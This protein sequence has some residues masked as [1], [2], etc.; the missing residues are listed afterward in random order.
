VNA[1][2]A[3][4]DNQ[5]HIDRQPLATTGAAILISADAMATMPFAYQIA[6]RQ[7][8]RLSVPAVA[9]KRPCDGAYRELASPPGRIIITKTGI[10]RTVVHQTE[11]HQDLDLRLSQSPHQLGR[12]RICAGAHNQ[13]IAGRSDLGAEIREAFQKVCDT[14]RHSI[15]ASSK[16]GTT[17][18]SSSLSIGWDAGCHRPGLKGVRLPFQVGSGAGAVTTSQATDSAALV[19]WRSVTL[20]PRVT[21]EFAVKAAE[22]KGCDGVT[23]AEAGR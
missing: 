10:P 8:H 20:S 5:S 7:P 14:G 12:D 19:D 11:R 9:A 22:C 4:V 6:E 23:D 1:R 17:S 16:A 3:L 18:L 15:S 21:D 13:P 2:A